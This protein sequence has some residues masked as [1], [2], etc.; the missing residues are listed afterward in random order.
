[1]VL[2][3]AAIIDTVVD[4][5]GEVV[6]NGVD[7]V[8]AAGLDTK[9]IVEL[10]VVVVVGGDVADVVIISA[11]ETDLPVP[12][13][14]YEQDEHSPLEWLQNMAYRRIC[15]TPQRALAYSQGSFK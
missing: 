11:N 1:M 14:I 12:V 10:S 9:A 15:K 7:D 2:V 8:V 6:D 13:Y 5:V 3:D 4:I